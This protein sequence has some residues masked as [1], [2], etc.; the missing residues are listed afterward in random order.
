MSYRFYKTGPRGGTTKKPFYLCFLDLKEAFDT[1][2][3]DILFNKISKTGVR[4][5]MLRVIQNLFS[6]NLANVLVDGFLSPEFLN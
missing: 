3:R 6:G 1:V 5:K 2:L 4:G